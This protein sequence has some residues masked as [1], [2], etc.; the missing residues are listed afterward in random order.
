[1]PCS[2]PWRHHRCSSTSPVALNP[3]EGL[4]C[5][6]K[7]GLTVQPWESHGSDFSSVIGSF[8]AC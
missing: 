7:L 6:Q 8:L 3:P 5:R 1:L 2:P 4:I